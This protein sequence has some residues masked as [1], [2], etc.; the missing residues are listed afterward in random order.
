MRYMGRELRQVAF[1]DTDS[2]FEARMTGIGASEAAA[3]SGLSDYQTPLHIYHR[4][5]G[6]L[7]ESRSDPDYVRLG[8]KLEPVVLSEILEHEQLDESCVVSFPSPM[9]RHESHD[10]VLATPD[11]MMVEDTLAEL[12]TTSSWMAKKLGEEG[13][14]YVPT[15]W[16]CQAQ[17]QMAVTGAGVVIFGVLVDG[18]HFKPFRVERNDTI[19]DSLMNA[20]GE[21]WQRIQAGD[22]P[23]ANYEHPHTH[24]LM[25]QLYDIDEAK[26]KTLSE[27]HAQAFLDNERIK[28]QIKELE[29]AKRA[30]DSLLLEGMADAAVGLIPEAGVAL[31][32]YRVAEKDVSYTRRSYVALRA[33]KLSS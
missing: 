4:K 22:P 12:K 13:T 28:A 23:D 19:I 32:R 5:R 27:K 9:F 8:K 26:T 10:E 25:K 24:S 21:L 33:S 31:R 14:D 2:W 1:P 7:D 20:E 16:L 6:N 15:E 29:A 3:A 11:V 18:R 30:N 17:Q